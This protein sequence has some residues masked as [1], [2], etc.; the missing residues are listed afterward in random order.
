MNTNTLKTAL[1]GNALFSALSGIALIIFHR[2]AADLFGLEQSRPF[3]I[4][5]LLL[6]PF[7][8]SV[9]VEF[10]KMR[11]KNILFIV[12]QDGLWVAGSLV[13]LV[14]QPFGISPAGHWIIGA[15][16]AM[17]LL[18]GVGQS[19]GI[20]QADSVSSYSRKVLSFERTVAASRSDVWE[21]ISQVSEYQSVAPNIDAAEIL[22]GEREGM[23]RRCASGEDRWTETCTEWKEGRRFSFEVDTSAPDYP[24]PFTFFKGT[25]MSE[26][27]TPGKSTIKMAF[28]FDYGNTLKAL[29][30]HPFIRTTFR[31]ICGRLLD[32]WEKQLGEAQPAEA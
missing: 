28:E 19:I 1:L 9:W 3:W 13:L 31:D 6:L 27:G 16:A 32:N 8:F 17:V 25:W 5:G 21:L 30:L 12:L 15:V 10:R 14:L 22:S 18:F 7:A 4:T 2:Q 26:E 24:Y 11:L 23:V 20:L 29:A